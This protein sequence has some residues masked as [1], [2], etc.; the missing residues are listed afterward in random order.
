MTA[1]LMLSCNKNRFDFDEL[2]SV[3][4]SGQW[5]LPIGSAHITLGEVMKQ[6]GENEWISYDENGNLQIR[7]SV[8]V[9]NL[10]KGSNFLSLGT[11]NFN[12]DL[13][14]PNPFTVDTLPAPIDT[15]KLVQQ[16]IKLNPD[17]V[18]IES[19][20]IKSG[21]LLFTMQGNLVNHVSQVEISSS[22]I[23]MPNGDTLYTTDVE[24]DLTGATFRLHDE[25]GNADSTLVLNY[26]I[27]YQITGI[28]DPD[29]EAVLLIGFN[30][31]K[32]KELSGYINEF[33]YEFVAD[34]TFAL[35]LDN[36]TGELSL[37]GAKISIKE[38]NTFVNLHAYL[39]VQQAELYGGTANPSQIFDHYP[40]VLDVIPASSYVNIMDNETVN[41]TYNTEFEGIRFKGSVDFNP[42]GTDQLMIVYDTSAIS[43]GINA[44]VPMQF[45]VPEVTY[46]DTLDLNLGE[47]T[48]PSLVNKIVLNTLFRS[49]IPFNLR[50]QFYTYNSRVG[51]VTGKLLEQDMVI[52][53]SF[54]GS[55]VVSDRD[56]TLTNE[57]VQRLLEADKLIMNFSVDTDNHDVMLNLDNGL[58]VTLKADVF[59]G[60]SISLNN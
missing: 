1:L 59:Y 27:H 51:M 22:D 38:K 16:I 8:E 49:Q 47:I 48:T 10:I 44:Y 37:V 25:Y 55:P 53:G 11:L 45:N 3:E 29:Y 32:L 4:G 41:L 33:T 40:Y 12:T 18:T 34:T 5:K 19:A 35:P 50:A 52:D 14:F 58:G 15:V 57:L 6:F 39:A 28:A 20:V 9:K 60:G 54:D 43:L 13:S 46:V 56:I 42:A 7:R 2:E 17:S 26:I 36:V 24:T 23:T 31:L 21:T 30:D